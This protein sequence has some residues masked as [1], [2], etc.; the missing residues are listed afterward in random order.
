M[1]VPSL[2]YFPG[3]MQENK[4]HNTLFSDSIK[5][6]NIHSHEESFTIYGQMKKMELQNSMISIPFIHKNTK[7]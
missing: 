6:K 5:I 1:T 7:Y 4:Q 3:G 2:D